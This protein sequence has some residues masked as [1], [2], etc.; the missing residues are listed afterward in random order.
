MKP[1]I[2]S[3]TFLLQGIV[4]DIKLDK[5]DALGPE[6]VLGVNG[7]KEARGA[8]SPDEAGSVSSAEPEGITAAGGMDVDDDSRDTSSEVAPA[9][10]D[11]ESV[12]TV[13]KVRI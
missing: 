8:D 5:L 2:P 11:K 12:R 13:V 9:Q 6:P 7:Q 4:P 10:K 1:C 3:V